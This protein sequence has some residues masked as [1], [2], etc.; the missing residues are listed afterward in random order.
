MDWNMVERN[1]GQYKG[2]IKEQWGNLTDDELSII[3]G[4]RDN[5]ERKIEERYHLTKDA[6]HRAVDDWM[7]RH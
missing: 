3:A 5:L 4:K 2:K 6:A 1:W 7:K